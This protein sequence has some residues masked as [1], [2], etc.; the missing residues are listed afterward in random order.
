MSVWWLTAPYR[1]VW[2]V[3]ILSIHVQDGFDLRYQNGLPEYGGLSEDELSEDGD[4]YNTEMR[5]KLTCKNGSDNPFF[6]WKIY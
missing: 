2:G 3:F 4:R 6:F 5:D 1:L